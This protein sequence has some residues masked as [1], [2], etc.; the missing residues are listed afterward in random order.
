M[1]KRLAP[2]VLMLALI[3]C[4]RG[5]ELTVLAQDELPSELYGESVRTVTDERTVRASLYFVQT[6]EEGVP[7]SPPKL[8]KIERESEPST[9][10]E[11]EILVDLLL[12]NPTAGE[13]TLRTAIPGDGPAGPDPDTELLSISVEDGLADVNLSAQFESAESE[14]L[15]LM[16]VAQVVYTLTELS[17]I[18]AVRFSIHGA[19]QPVVDQDGMAHEMV[20]REQYSR[21]APVASELGEEGESQ[22]RAD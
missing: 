11:A 17:D 21:F 9:L 6:N 22:I 19:P 16:R 8:A 1:T 10:P 12:A 15:Q 5:T 20:S 4:S 13:A 3:G 14:L 18:D 2:L 7:L